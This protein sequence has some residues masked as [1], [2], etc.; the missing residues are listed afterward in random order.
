M[1]I[2]QSELPSAF[3][4]LL[5]VMSFRFVIIIL[6]AIFGLNPRTGIDTVSFANEANKIANQFLSGNYRD[7][8]SNALGTTN[9]YWGILISPFWMIPGPSEVY[10][11]LFVAFLSAVGIYNVY[12]MGWYHHSHKAGMFAIIPL[13]IAPSFVTVQGSIFRD[14]VVFFALTTAARYL[15]IP[16][17][18]LKLRIIAP[19]V[20][21]GLA[22]YLRDYTFVIYSIALLSGTIAYFSY[23]NHW[24]RR[25]LYASPI[26]VLPVT[27][28][29]RET[30]EQQLLSIVSTRTYATRG[31]A[32][33]LSEVFP[34][35]LSEVIA[36]SWIGALYFLFS[37]FPWQITAPIDIGAS[38]ESLIFL[39]F[40]IPAVFGVRYM[41]HRECAVT[42]GILAGFFVGVI[43]VGLGSGNYGTAI[44]HRQMF[45]WV[46]TLYGG[47]GLVHTVDLKGLDRFIQ[48]FLTE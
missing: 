48:S 3:R 31:R 12:V 9:E 45:L 24:V 43:L 8:A 29:L 33:Y 22:Y 16:K 34:G 18:P 15:S 40:T 1:G 5:F 13:I 17:Y 25:L 41:L 2:H 39:L 28:L 44:R 47:I 20:S 36:F 23:S 27:I 11:S 4:I 46:V 32:A 42:V 6:D 10:A 14:G 35:T 26:A 38:F 21:L 7:F 30:I 19:V 37:P